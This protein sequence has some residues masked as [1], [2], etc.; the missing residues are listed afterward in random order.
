MAKA[1]AIVTGL[2]GASADSA[3]INFQYCSGGTVDSSSITAD[4]TQSQ[5][6][7]AAQIREAVSDALVPAGITVDPAD[8]T[9]LFYPS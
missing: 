8:V 3:V 9:L 6:T 4:L 5:A 2:G 7:I 1:T